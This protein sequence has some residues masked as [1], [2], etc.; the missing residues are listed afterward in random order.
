MTKAMDHKATPK[1]NAKQTDAVEIL[2][3]DHREVEGLFEEFEALKDGS[4]TKKA[5]VVRK[6]CAALI[7]HA[8]IEEEIFYPALRE[9]DVD[10][11]IMDEADIEHAGA[12][13]LIGQ[14]EEMEPGDDHYDAKVKVLGEYIKH[15]V[16][17]EEAEM[18]RAA[19]ASQVDL[20]TLATELSDRKAELN[21][22]T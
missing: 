6:I 15:H 16:K 2:K 11:D 10:A 4:S 7:V 21:A 8:A 3:S 20:E 22:G 17:E 14:L 13:A 19:R 5:A 9:A 1:S 12:K 18:F